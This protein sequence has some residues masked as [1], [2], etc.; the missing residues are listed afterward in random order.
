MTQRYL[1]QRYVE[2]NLQV[3][4]QSHTNTGPSM[5]GSEELAEG[6]YHKIL[7]LAWKKKE[8]CRENT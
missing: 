6:L 5:R 7:W 4:K 1:A 8:D 2:S 3:L